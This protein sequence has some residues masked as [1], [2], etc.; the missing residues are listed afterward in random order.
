MSTAAEFK[1]KGNGFL[2]AGKFAEAIEAYSK[3]IELN[4]S[5][6]VF[7]S[8]RSAAYLSKGD[9][10]NALADGAKCIEISPNWAK[11]YSRKGAALHALKQYDDAVE[12][13][14]EGLK[15]CPGDSG[16]VNGLSEVNKAKEAS[17]SRGGGLGGLFSNPQFLSK[18]AGHPKYGPKLADP[19]FLKKL[20]MMQ[21]NPQLMMSDPDMM[22]VLTIMLGGAGG[23][24]DGGDFGDEP[25]GASSSS[26][27]YQPSSSTSSSANSKPYSAPPRDEHLTEE[28]KADRQ[29]KATAAAAK[30]KGNTLY[31]GKECFKNDHY[32]SALALI[33]LISTEIPY[34]MS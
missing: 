34:L 23:G 19:T 25:L 31:K 24:E 16:L 1:E 17:E 10:E 8:N 14:N 9:A 11:G 29:R 22:E 2:Q 20:Q 15:Q 28:E 27:S 7:Y 13:Y 12:T 5:D 26:S 6:H 4:P 32:R 3:A 21:S 33:T 18:L 30:E